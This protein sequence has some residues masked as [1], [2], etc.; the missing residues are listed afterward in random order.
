MWWPDPWE[1]PLSDIA[2]YDWVILDDWVSEFITPLKALNPDIMLLNSTNACELGFN[3]DPE[4]W[5]NQ[6]VLAI[7]PEWF[8]TQVGS[9][10]TADVDAMTT[11]F[12]VA[13]VTTTDGISVYELFVVSDT[14]LI[15]DE[16]VFVEAVDPEAKTLTV[17]RGYVRPAA[18]HSAGTRLAAH[19]A[20]WPN[21][22]L[23]NLST[24]CPT[25]VVSP[26]VGPETWAEYNARIAANLLSNPLWNGILIDRSDPDESWLIGNS[27]ART[28]DPDQ[29]NTL[30]TDYT[31]FDAAWNVGRQL[32]DGE[33]RPAQRQQL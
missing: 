32:G 23:L 24:F 33:L 8:L 3:P 16:S 25:A 11:T 4:P 7:P 15:A 17:R 19:I 30:I 20:F 2:R 12:H 18:P 21:S 29:S 6:D 14:V 28:I 31:A 13:A 1:Q 5:E 27:T 26:T 10:L 9:E 22:W